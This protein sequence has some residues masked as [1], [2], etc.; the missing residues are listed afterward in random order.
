MMAIA[1][2]SKKG[3]VVIPKKIRELTRLEPGDRVIFTVTKK[4]TLITKQMESPFDKYYGF[5]NRPSSSDIIV[6]TIRGERDD[7][8]S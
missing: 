5:L 2:I 4:G 7:S 3:Q 1:K 8:V 6:R